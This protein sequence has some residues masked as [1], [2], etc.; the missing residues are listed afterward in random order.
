MR[1]PFRSGPRHIGTVTEPT[2]GGGACSI[3]TLRPAFSAFAATNA[4]NGIMCTN[5]EYPEAV[6]SPQYVESCMG[7]PACGQ[8][9]CGCVG[10]YPESVMAEWH[11]GLGHKAESCYPYRFTG[12]ALDHF[13][14][15]MQVVSCEDAYDPSYNELCA[16]EDFHY[17]SDAASDN[18]QY[19]GYLWAYLTP[20]EASNL[21][22][23]IRNVGPITVSFAVHD[24]FFNHDFS[25]GPRC[26]YPG[27]D[28]FPEG[29]Y[30]AGYHA[31]T[32][33]GFGSFEEANGDT[34]EYW[35]SSQVIIFVGKESSFTL[36]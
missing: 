23:V 34:T 19:W 36:A 25:C 14:A 20:S 21:K 8:A 33:T 10:G 17:L 28:G 27:D 3:L 1:S 29:D 6:L 15:E 9:Q 32:I 11:L 26:W 4:I 24:S 18:P 5:G 22:N 13:D 31:T 7:E 12:D 35:V 16:T 2:Q 30:V